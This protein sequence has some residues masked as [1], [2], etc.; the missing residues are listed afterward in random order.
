LRVK[1]SLSVRGIVVL[2]TRSLLGTPMS[3]TRSRLGST[4]DAA[5]YS[6]LE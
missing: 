3:S 2:A 5:H 4:V 6:T 1:T